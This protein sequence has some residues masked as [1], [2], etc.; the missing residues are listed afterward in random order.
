MY[1]QG[2]ST[3]DQPNQSNQPIQPS[4]APVDP[5]T[6]QTTVQ[7]PTAVQQPAPQQTTP[8]PNPQTLPPQ[9]PKPQQIPTKKKSSI[10]PFV[11]IAV[12]VIIAIGAF[13]FLYV[14]GSILKTTT[15]SSATTTA[16]KNIYA[17][18]N[19][20]NINSPGSYFVESGIK[21]G[22]TSGACINITSDN[23]NLVCNSN[24]ITGSGPFVG[25]A[26]FTYGIEIDGKQNVTISGCDVR[27]FSYGVFA[28]SSQNI[29]L[30][31]NNFSINYVSNIYL[32]NTHQSAIYQNYLS[33]SSSTQGSLYLTN[34]TT[35]ITVYNNTIQYDQYYGINVNSSNNVFKNNYI[36]GTQYSFYCSAANGFVKSSLGLSNSCYNDSGCGFLT[37]K[38][39]N[40]PANLSKIILNNQISTCG[41]I[42]NSGTYSLDS[43]LYMNQ[44]V[45]TSNPLSSTMA[46]ISINAKNVVLN[47]KGLGI[48]NSTTAIVA[49]LST[50]V[51]VENCDVKNSQNAGIVLYNSSQVHLYNLSIVSDF[52]GIEIVNSTVDTLENVSATQNYY[53]I[54]LSGSYSNSFIN[55]NS[56]HNTYGLYV[57]NGS[58]SN[59]FLKAIIEN[60]SNID[61][62]ASPDSSGATLNLMQ[63]TKCG[64]TNAVWAGCTHFVETALSYV[65]INSCSSISAPGNYLLT[66]SVLNAGS[67]CI[68][69]LS[70]NVKF[71]CKN[72]TISSSF[73]TQGPAISIKNANNVTV[74]ECNVNGYTSSINATNSTDVQITNL[75]V[76]GSN[77]GIIF[78][79]VGTSSIVNATVNGTR[80]ASIALYS[81]SFNKLKYNN[82]TYGQGH[83]IGI[84]LNNSL[85]NKVLN[86]SA[87]EEYIGYQITAQ[88]QNNTISN[89]TAASSAYYDYIC[90]GMG[91]S[92]I[93]AENGGINYGTT[94]IGC[95]WL[96]AITK[97]N[98]VINC[99]S[100][101]QPTLYTLSQ[102]GVYAVG[103][104]CISSFGSQ[105]TIDCNGHTIIAT[106]NGTF[107]SLTNS[108]NSKIYNCLLKGF[109]NPII[110]YNSSIV[111]Q[112]NTIF[113][114]NSNSNAISI[115]DV[116][117]QTVGI[118]IN[119]VINVHDAFDLSNLG[120]AEL[121]N[122]IAYNTDTAYYLSN[123]SAASIK[124]NT[125][126]ASNNGIVLTNSQENYFQ[127][128]NF[129]G[130]SSGMECL[131][132]SIGAS[133]NT[134]L[135]N[136]R[137]NTN[138]NCLWI[139]SSSSLCP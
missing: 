127:N 78:N 82:I 49:A 3:P 116:P 53:G 12:V 58:L 86:N 30:I 139:K 73:S 17:I 135:S 132:R 117:T 69:I 74:N 85:S 110:A 13:G 34:G 22:I 56:T 122:N 100:V 120:A 27:N 99:I 75:R 42:R 41:S 18:S 20:E 15:T 112:N 33:R 39:I 131:L 26:P 11:I 40:T 77:Y 6:Q 84:L 107:A 108:A 123:I 31:T 46:C 81:S 102:D 66:T 76:S 35:G 136:N 130:S 45:N 83:D 101:N 111:V 109:A 50:N 72:D 121:L 134:D 137:C 57:T 125:A 129:Q 124:N 9:P 88:S 8:Q 96:A 25:Y 68:K 63:S 52:D 62:Y 16:V 104:T 133:N 4:P 61:V 90:N 97:I 51:T 10:L 105:I 29:N 126:Y 128:N 113:G 24:K 1:N 5:S 55:L 38:G 95:E 119:N 32:N 67:Q 36:N 70:S 2:P 59:S 80:N 21:T 98:P 94:K 92:S 79:R 23:V 87:V 48:Y 43:N 7:Q 54:L 138:L 65:P 118:Y 14:N 19:C 71:S 103:S 37:C 64:Y 28:L 114:L 115:H 106:N 91:T 89:N 47:C 93:N 44:F 60:N